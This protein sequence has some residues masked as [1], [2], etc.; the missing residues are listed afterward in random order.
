MAM[1]AVQHVSPPSSALLRGSIVQ[2][3]R[4]AS[5]LILF[6]FVLFHFLNHA[7]GIW[8]VAAMD[9]AQSWRTAVTR[10][11]PGALIL[12]AAL[13]IHMG[14][15][16][17]KI[18]RRSTWRMP[19]WE[20]VQIAL[21]LAIPVLLA[22]HAAPMRA[23]FDLEHSATHYSD[24]LADVWN[25][26][27][28]NQFALLLIVWV[29]S[30]LG[31]HYWLRLN[32]RYRRL[33]PALLAVAVVIPTLALSGFVVAGRAMAERAAAAQE[34]KEYGGSYDEYASAAP[35]TPAAAPT[36]GWTAASVTDFFVFAAW[37]LLAAVALALAVRLIL[38][39]RKR[40][41]RVDFVAGPSIVARVGP[42]LLE[43]SRQ[44]GVPHV[45]ICGGRAR[46][47]TC[48]V[49]VE[50]SSRPLPPPGAAEAATLAQIGAGPDV[51][52][53]CQ[54]RPRANLTVM[55]LVRPPDE[56][57]SLALGSADD[58]GAEHVL[59]IMFLDIRGF[60]SLSETR[61]PYDTVFLLNRFFAET[62][63]AVTGAGGWIDKYL[64]DGLMALF[65][66]RQP[67]EA[68]CRAA[69]S[70]AMGI[71][72]ALDRIN[73]EL[74]DEVAEP[75][76]IGMGLHVGPLVLGRIGH[77]TSASTTVI[78]PPVNVASRLEALTK[79]HRV[80]IV[81][82]TALARAA[83]LPEGAFS[84]TVVTVRGTSEPVG[85]TLIPRGRDLTPYLD[86]AVRRPSAA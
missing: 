17:Y 77:R 35:A 14:L 2:R 72:A 86:L 63:E 42:T 85:V 57:R 12:A 43:M 44:A 22:R 16:L 15:N 33:A 64:G 53:A 52:L 78:G 29:H 37:A 67:V 69:L 62:G 58:A 79:E 66:L 9:A 23:H 4:I 8:S 82:S 1:A 39:A 48:R 55:R 25:G 18:A 50:R 31:L 27:V 3:L 59:A 34:A 49:R 61:L 73:H 13:A 54:I 56:R 7:L 26:L 5:G 81:A 6:T 10:S 68:A 76:R 65:G 24:T 30:C 84:H 40:A 28:Y 80:Q 74:G 51:R 41:V 36:S 83:G 75:L 71:D 46:C 21:G 60:T 70:A 11:V 32:A 19:L 47:S 38:H 45:S 20:A